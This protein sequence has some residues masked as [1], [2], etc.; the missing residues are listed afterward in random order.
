MNVLGTN[1]RTA[2]GVLSEKFAKS[3]PGDLPVKMALMYSE[4][5]K[6]VATITRMVFINKFL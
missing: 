6:K 3:K 1:F 2:S 4:K 5:G